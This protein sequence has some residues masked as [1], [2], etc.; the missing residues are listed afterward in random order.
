VVKVYGKIIFF[1][2]FAEETF[3]DLGKKHKTFAKK[4]KTFFRKHFLSLKYVVLP[5][6]YDKS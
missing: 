1:V 4:R 2:I 3:A 6:S 5:K